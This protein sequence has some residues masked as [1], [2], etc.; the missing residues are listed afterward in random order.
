MTKCF[1]TLSA[2]L[3]ELGSVPANGLD[4]NKACLEV[5]DLESNKMHVFH[6]IY[7]SQNILNQFTCCSTL[8][9][10]L[11]SSHSL[12]L[13]NHKSTVQT[14]TQIVLYISKPHSQSTR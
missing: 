8:F 1:F 6:L 4:L 7:I 3:R 12:R 14:I 5:F 10:V 13:S 9:L 11:H 2:L